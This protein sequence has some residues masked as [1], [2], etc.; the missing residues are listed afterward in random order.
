M[1]LTVCIVV[2]NEEKH[3]SLIEENICLLRKDKRDIPILLIDNASADKT[4][5][6]LQRIA[7]QLSVDYILRDLNHLPQARQMAVE[8]CNT[9]W[10]GF[11]DADCRIDEKWLQSVIQKV[12]VISNKVAALGGPWQMAGD[13]KFQYEALFSTFCGHFGL[14]YL[15]SS[16]SHEK[17]VHHLPTANIVYRCKDILRVGGFSSKN[18]RVGEDLD[19]SQRLIEHGLQILFYPHMKIEHFLPPSLISWFSKMFIYGQARGE[20]LWNYKNFSYVSCLPL[21]GFFF[22]V[23]LLMLSP[24]HFLGFII[25]YILICLSVAL[26]SAR[27]ALV[28]RVF[29]LLLGTHSFYAVGIVYGFLKQM[30][31]SV[32]EQRLFLSRRTAQEPESV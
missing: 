12:Q 30:L 4:S 21:L 28:L 17:W 10:L 19:L 29:Y 1:S 23:V 3:L 2:Y 25:V 5:S 16:F 7:Q 20:L 26:H 24:P 9:D 6:S 27:N 32:L 22:L 11:I 13:G 15:Q 31:Q 8:L 14:V 18:A